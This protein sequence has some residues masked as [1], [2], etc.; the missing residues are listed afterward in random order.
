MPVSSRP[1]V[2]VG[3]IITAGLCLFLAVQTAALL[4]PF[5]LPNSYSWI[6]APLVLLMIALGAFLRARKKQGDS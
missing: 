3:A 6:P 2:L 4:L 5:V 1:V